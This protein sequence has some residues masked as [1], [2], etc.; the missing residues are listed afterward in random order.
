MTEVNFVCIGFIICNIAISIRELKLSKYIQYLHQQVIS[1]FNSP[2][3]HWNKQQASNPPPLLVYYL[4]RN[5]VKN[6]PKG[7]GGGI[8]KKVPISIWEFSKIAFRSHPKKENRSTLF[9]PLKANMPFRI[10]S[11]W[12]E[13]LLP[14][15][16]LIQKYLNFIW[17]GLGV[18]KRGGVSILR[19]FWNFKKNL[20]Y[21][22]WINS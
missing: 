21:A 10:T 3:L 7:K 8:E 13:L 4:N 17:L 15:C 19:K 2:L 14:M 11:F 22:F 1:H 5:L 20:I 18:G 9:G 6:N 12:R 16:S